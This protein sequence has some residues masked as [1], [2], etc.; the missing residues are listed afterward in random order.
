MP[1]SKSLAR[2]IFKPVIDFSSLALFSNNSNLT[3]SSP[4]ENL[5]ENQNLFFF[6]KTIKFREFPIVFNI[7]VKISLKF[8]SNITTKNSNQRNIIMVLF[9]LVKRIWRNMTIG[10]RGKKRINK[11]HLNMVSGHFELDLMTSE[12]TKMAMGAGSHITDTE[13]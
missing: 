7:S 12:Y 3:S 13:T 11:I 9:L 4:E 6:S 2:W 5:L 10:T 8:F 1:N